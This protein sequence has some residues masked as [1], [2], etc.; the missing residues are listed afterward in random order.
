MNDKDKAVAK[1]LLYIISFVI[2]FLVAEF[3]L[4]YSF[5][6]TAAAYPY[7]IYVVSA[8][9]AAVVAVAPVRHFFPET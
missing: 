4:V 2:V 5:P 1:G 8:A 9:I 7:I 3:I 6:D